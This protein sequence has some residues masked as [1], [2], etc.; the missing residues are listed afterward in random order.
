MDGSGKFF[1]TDTEKT[2]PQL[3]AD[4]LPYVV[5]KVVVETTSLSALIGDVAVVTHHDWTM[6]LV[7]V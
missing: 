6:C 2:V 3:I 1:E 4:T 7:A 5:L